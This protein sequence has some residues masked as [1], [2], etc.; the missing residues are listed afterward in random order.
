[1][2]IAALAAQHCV[3][4]KKFGALYEVEMGLGDASLLLL[5]LL[6]RWRLIGER[7]GGRD[8]CRT[9]L[10]QASAGGLAVT[11]QPPI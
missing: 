6:S 10:D 7:I 2:S 9:K 5:L 8:E 3:G 11:G 4:Y 1:L